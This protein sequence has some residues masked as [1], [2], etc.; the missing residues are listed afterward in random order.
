MGLF[1]SVVC[2]FSCSGAPGA[3]TGA[4]PEAGRGDGL[5]AEP[6]LGGPGLAATARVGEMKSEV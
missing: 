3:E 6:E 5:P 1:A 2:L 4:G